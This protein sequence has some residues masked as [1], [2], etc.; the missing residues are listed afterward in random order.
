[1]RV[2]ASSHSRATTTRRTAD[3]GPGLRTWH[4]PPVGAP[5]AID[6]FSGAGGAS[7]GLVEAGFDLRLAVD[8]DPPSAET[9]H[10]NLPGEFLLGDLRVLEAEKICRAADVAPGDLDLL[11]AGPPCQGFSILGSRVVWDRRNNLF[12]EILR[13]TAEL[14]PRCTVV[15]NVPGLATLANGAY[16]RALLAGLG[17]IGYSAACA[18]LLA[19]QYGAPQIRWRLIVVAWRN[20]LQILLVT[21]SPPLRTARARLVHLCRTAPSAVTRWQASSI[22]VTQ[23]ATF[24]KSNQV[25]VRITM[26]VRRTRFISER[27]AQVSTTSSSITMRLACHRPISLGFVTSVQVKIG[28]N[29]PE[30]CCPQVCGERFGRTTP[31]G[32]GA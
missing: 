25:A 10:A 17:E 12:L 2:P 16:L 19:A 20:D 30:K 11:F 14:R 1:M 7:R 27:C 18:E 6:L 13:L 28:G 5:S 9:H 26:A 15:E 31:A 8:V 21:D 3:R 4:T 22:R 32:I 24:R 29:F 23:L